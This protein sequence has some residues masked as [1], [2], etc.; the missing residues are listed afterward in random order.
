M[1][2]STQVDP[3]RY[4]E[5]ALSVARARSL[6]ETLRAIVDALWAMPNFALVRIWL[7]APGDVCDSCPMRSECPDQTE[8]LHLVASAGSPKSKSTKQWDRLDGDFSRIPLGIRKVG[9]VA[10]TAE[11]VLRSRIVDDAWIARP[12]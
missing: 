6:P 4:Q 1:L 12:K 11:P 8:C 3:K 9:L 2:A 7:K 10:S 5:I